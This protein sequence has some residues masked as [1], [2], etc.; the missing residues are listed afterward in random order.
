VFFSG[1]QYLV[2]VKL[3]AR[4]VGGKAGAAQLEDRLMRAAPFRTALQNQAIARLAQV[5]GVHGK[6]SP[7]FRA[8]LAD[9]MA[10]WG[11]RPA[12]GMASTPSIP[13]WRE[14]PAQV[15]GLVDA[16]LSD[17]NAPTPDAA[18]RQQQADYEAARTEVERALW[19]PLRGWYRTS[20]EMARRGVVAREDSLFRMEALTDGIRQTV[21]RLGERLVREGRLAEPADVFFL[22]A[23]ELEPVAA[24]KLPAIEL[25]R[26][27]RQGYAR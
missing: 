16:L 8:A 19:A 5:A 7:E 10:E 1:I 9:F 11:T 18:L 17:P 6:D 12:R 21:L 13:S 23:S 15:L 2:L 4:L 25:V 3:W 14:E 22:L 20:L 24:G 27:R 26:R